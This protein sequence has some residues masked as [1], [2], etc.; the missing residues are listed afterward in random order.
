[1][2]Q[3][4]K[5]DRAVLWGLATATISIGFAVALYNPGFLSFRLFS[6]GEFVGHM[7]PLL[8]VALFI[9]RA[10]EVFLNG[11]RAKRVA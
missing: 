8:M 7:L 1:M 5:N 9:E 11:W 3:I 6:A 2:E 4:A 10:L